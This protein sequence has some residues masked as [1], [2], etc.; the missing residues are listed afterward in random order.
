MKI[1]A[2]VLAMVLSLVG[3][4]GFASAQSTLSP[5]GN[6][7]VTV[8]QLTYNHVFPVFRVINNNAYPV[9]VRFVQPTTP[10]VTMMLPAGTSRDLGNFEAYKYFVCSNGG[11]PVIKGT[12]VPAEYGNDWSETSCQ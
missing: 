2:I 3:F 6:G 10:G 9:V 7:G 1:K 8:I 4:V 5:D 12:T 11:S